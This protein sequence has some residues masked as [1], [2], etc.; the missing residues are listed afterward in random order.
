[1]A[2]GVRLTER[3]KAS[4]FF[5]PRPAPENLEDACEPQASVLW[6]F[7]FGLKMCLLE[8]VVASFELFGEMLYMPELL[9]EDVA[10]EVLEGSAGLGDVIHALLPSNL[11]PPVARL[12]GSLLLRG[13]AFLLNFFSRSFT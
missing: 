1:M 10:V 7:L 9:L 4:L 5:C 3:F 12:V 11:K 2:S 6:R 13:V 8:D